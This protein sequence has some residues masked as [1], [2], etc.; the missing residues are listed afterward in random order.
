MLYFKPISCAVQ[1]Q[2]VLEKLSPPPGLQ[3]LA[4]AVARIGQPARLA[5]GPIVPSAASEARQAPLRA[6]LKQGPQPQVSQLPPLPV[7]NIL[8]IPVHVSEAVCLCTCCQALLK[9][10]LVSFIRQVCCQAIS[11]NYACGLPVA[12]T[13]TDQCIACTG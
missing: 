7:A 13:S 6:H 4:A 5:P 10:C 11:I 8:G 2:T 3:L 12:S 9:K 1:A